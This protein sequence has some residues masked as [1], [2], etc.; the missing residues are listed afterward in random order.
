MT[1]KEALSKIPANLHGVADS[2][3]AA[4]FDWKTILAVALD[5]LQKL[6]QPKAQA[7]AP[8]ACGD[9]VK[10]HLRCLRTKAGDLYLDACCACH[11]ADC[12]D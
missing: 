7:A 1:R 9:D 11:C 10:D 8:L 2:M 4:G 6:L 3:E 5:I 12:C